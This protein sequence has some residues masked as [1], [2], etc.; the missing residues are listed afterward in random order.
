L[1]RTGEGL[2]GQENKESGRGPVASLADGGSLDSR[3]GNG[4]RAGFK[5]A[6][7]SR[8]ALA[9]LGNGAAGRW[10][11]KSLE[12]CGQR[13]E[14]RT[15]NRSRLSDKEEG[16]SKRKLLGAAENN[17]KRCDVQWA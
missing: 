2:A 4:K 17:G 12:K 7:S 6:W 11:S 14:A 15:K 1:P 3:G 8:A 13:G 5:N 10:G 16:T 9:K